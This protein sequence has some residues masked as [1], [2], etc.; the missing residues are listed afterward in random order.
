VYGELPE[1]KKAPEVLVGGR[2]RPLLKIWRPGAVVI[3]IGDRRNKD[4]QSLL[5]HMRKEAGATLFYLSQTRETTTWAE[6]STACCT[7]GVTIP[8]IGWKLPPKRKLGDSEHYSMS[9][10]ER[11]DCFQLNILLRFD[12]RIRALPVRRY[13]ISDGRWF[14]HRSVVDRRLHTRASRLFSSG[15]AVCS[16][17]RQICSSE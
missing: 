3:R 4:V 9:I 5:K 12:D 1:N 7:D 16:R 13:R 2:L 10:F 14:S 11:Y 6:A 8:E 15:R 17:W